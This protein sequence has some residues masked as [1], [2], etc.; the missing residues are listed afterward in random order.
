MKVKDLWLSLCS[1]SG[2]VE[3]S[4]YRALA[5]GDGFTQT[6]PTAPQRLLFEDDWRSADASPMEIDGNFDA[7]G[8]FDEGDALRHPV[9]FSV[10][11]HCPC[12]CA[13]AGALAGN[14]ERQGFGFRDSANRKVT[15]LVKSDWT[16]LFN[17]S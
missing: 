6:L 9:V 4:E 17:F 15:Q 1:I 13:C 16:R 10:E 3:P 12:N 8:D 14:R 7:V 2:I 5:P 11:G